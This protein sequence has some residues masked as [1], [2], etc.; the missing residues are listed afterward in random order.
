[1]I[2]MNV[3]DYV[4]SSMTDFVSKNPQY[5]SDQNISFYDSGNII[6]PKMVVK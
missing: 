6:N 4:I 2:V 3:F 5:F 1:M